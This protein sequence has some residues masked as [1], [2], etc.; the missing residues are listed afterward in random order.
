MRYAR[1]GGPVK[2]E[3]YPLDPTPPAAMRE[4]AAAMT[5][6]DDAVTAAGRDS[7]SLRQLLRRRQRRAQYNPSASGS[8]RSSARAAASTSFI[9]LDDAAAATVLAL[10]NDVPPRSTTSSTTSPAPVRE[11]LPV[12]AE[13]LG[14]KPPRHFPRLARA[15]CS[16]ARLRSCW[17][18]EYPRRVECEGQ[19][20]ARLDLASPDL[21][22]RLRRGLRDTGSVD[23]RA[24]HA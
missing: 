2:T 4:T 7:A 19:A 13:A 9:H 23:N 14:A 8:S 16:R 11:W 10:E 17:G 5:Y 21:A 1:E 22:A 20:R 15:T 3:G 24:S 18:T 6:L 12:F